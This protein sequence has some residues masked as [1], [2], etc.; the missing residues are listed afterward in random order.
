VLACDGKIDRD[1]LG[2]SEVAA[3]LDSEAVRG[4]RQAQSPGGED[5]RCVRGPDVQPKLDARSPVS[6][7][8]LLVLLVNL[9]SYES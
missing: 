4:P 8:L 6:G 2:V 7:I 3:G 9:Y 1:R 5:Q